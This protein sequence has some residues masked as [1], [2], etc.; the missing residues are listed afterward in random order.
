MHICKL[1]P[2]TLLPTLG[3]LGIERVDKPTSAMPRGGRHRNAS[4]MPVSA[5]RQ[6][7]VDMNIDGFQKPSVP[8]GSQMGNFRSPGTNLTSEEHFALT[9]NVCSASTNAATVLQFC[10]PIAS[11][12]SLGGP[13]HPTATNPTYGSASARA[14]NVVRSSGVANKATISQRGH[15]SG[16]GSSGVA[17]VLGTGSEPVASAPLE[18]PDVDSPEL[19]FRKVKALLNK[20]TIERFDL[21][22]DDIIHWA[23]KSENEK[24]GRTLIQVIR[25]V[26]EHAMDEPAWSEMYARLCRKMMDQI[27]PDVQD[28]GIIAGGLLF[29]TYLLNRCKEDFE[30]GWL[31]KEATAAVAAAKASDS[32][33]TKAAHAKKGTEKAELHF[34]EHYA[35]QKAKRQC[36]SLVK[37][38]CEL[39]KLQMLTERIMH[40]CVKKLLGNV[41]DP[42]GEEIK[43]LCQLFKAGWPELGKS[44]NVNPRVQFML[45]DI[46]ELRDRRW[47]GRNV[48]A[49]PVTF[50]VVYEAAVYRQVRISRGGRRLGGEQDQE[51][52]PDSWA[53]ASGSVAQAPPKLGEVSLV[54]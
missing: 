37:F 53:V 40:D 5:N 11:A 28:E 13:D 49:A 32:Q 38:I 47:V 54:A 46:F 45:Q 4:A 29:Q 14:P 25:V 50:A 26:F 6:A 24:D 15:G 18:F 48:V 1:K 12:P 7:S 41:K 27:S 51:Q 9:S 35:A 30:R 20:L 33:A 42:E 21:I 17:P 3:V 10:S 43:S 22:S 36:F 52:G 44:Q 39:F 31:A 19:V 34:D 16:F 23:N 8:N 2:P